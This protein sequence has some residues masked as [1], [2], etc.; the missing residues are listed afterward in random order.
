M[1]HTALARKHRP[2]SF[3][4]V[5]G[6]DHVT[7]TLQNALRE[8]RLTHA[9]LFSGPRGSGKTTTARLLAKAVQCE[10]GPTPHPC[11][12]CEFCREAAAGTSLDIIEM[13]AA[14]HTGV[15]DVRGLQERLAYAPSKARRKVYIVDEVH[16][17]SKSAWNAF[18]KTLEEPPPHIL[19]IFATT[20]PE[21][22]LETI[23]SRCQRFHFRRLGLEEIEV[24][25][26]SI[27]SKEGLRVDD[28]ALRLLASRGDG[29]MRDAET[30]LDQISAALTEGVTVEGI[31]EV[32]GLADWRLIHALLEAIIARDHAGALRQVD[33]AFREGVDMNELALSLLE[34]LRNLLVL[35]VEA[36]L[37][38]RFPISGEERSNLDRLAREGSTVDFLSLLRQATS[39]YREIKASPHPRFSFERGVLELSHHESQVLI[40]DLLERIPG[41]SGEGGSRQ[42]PGEGVEP[43]A[44]KRHR[45]DAAARSAAQ[46]DTT[47]FDDTDPLASPSTG[48]VKAGTASVD[49]SLTTNGFEG[50][51]REDSSGMSSSNSVVPA[52]GD[53]VGWEGFL[54]E[55]SSRKAMLGAFLKQG[56]PGPISNETI[57]V[58]FEPGH[59]FSAEQLSRPENLRTVKGAFSEYSGRELEFRFVCGRKV[60]ESTASRIES[61]FEG[62]PERGL[63]EDQIRMLDERPLL[64]RIVDEFRGEVVA[65]RTANVPGGR[66]RS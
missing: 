19:F 50:R 11:N 33:T 9:Y 64:R 6:Q 53:E 7:R 32:L 31:R 44:K 63:S 1:A 43:K 41:G 42:G 8:D 65:D 37:A 24:R 35:T 4:E 47:V 34:G 49:R 21:K 61:P 54:Q 17:L 55:L 59:E 62:A 39:L 29:S 18:L 40:D 27:C 10:K 20:E 30:L 52:E 36:S 13:D 58:R 23:L 38:Q 12:S 48:A 22:V 3:E 26:R 25:L 5:V 46:V 60:E 56:S 28:D 51:G 2:Q 15:D 57:E 14:S 45:S 16:M 66:H